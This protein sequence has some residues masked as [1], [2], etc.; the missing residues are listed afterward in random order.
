M[1]SPQIIYLDREDDLVSI[2]DRLSWAREKRVLLVLPDGQSDLLQE[3][4]DL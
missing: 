2:R 1:T 3:W 4:L